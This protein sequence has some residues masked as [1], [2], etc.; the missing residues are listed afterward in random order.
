MEAMANQ[1]YEMSQ[2][3][4]L[5]PGVVVGVTNPEN[6]T[7]GVWVGSSGADRANIYSDKSTGEAINIHKHL[8]KFD[9]LGID[10]MV[11]TDLVAS[12]EREGG[13]ATGRFPEFVKKNGATEIFCAGDHSPYDVSL[14]WCDEGAA[15]D[16][17]VVQLVVPVWC[18]EAK[19]NVMMRAIICET[20]ASSYFT[21]FSLTFCVRSRA[22]RHGR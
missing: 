2:K 9:K 15:G 11:W 7:N 10:A 13:T 6:A 20:A 22:G 5:D 12:L 8:L 18:E 21:C 14:A 1:A 16:T 4:D 17:G 3:F 19:E